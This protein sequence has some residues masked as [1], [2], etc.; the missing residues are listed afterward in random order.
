MSRTQKAGREP[1]RQYR[2]RRILI[3]ADEIQPKHRRPSFREIALRH[4]SELNEGLCTVDAGISRASPGTLDGK[5]IA[6]AGGNQQVECRIG[7]R[8]GKF[9]HDSGR[10]TRR[11]TDLVTVSAVPQQVTD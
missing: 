5:R 11:N 4:K 8:I 3:L 9:N 7:V 1:L 10:F 2:F 6:N